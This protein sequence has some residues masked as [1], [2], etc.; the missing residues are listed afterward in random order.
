M[1]FATRTVLALKAAPQEV[2]RQLLLWPQTVSFWSF[3]VS[4]SRPSCTG[5]VGIGG[6]TDAGNEGR[7]HFG[8]LNDICSCSV[9]SV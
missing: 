7:E 2:L 4:A 1:R 8:E 6:N 5:F 9:L 3:Q